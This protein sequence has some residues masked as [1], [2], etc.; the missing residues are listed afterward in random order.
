[1]GRWGWLPDD[2]GVVGNLLQT[3][4]I[5]GLSA[6]IFEEGGR[7]LAFRFWAKDARRWGQGLMMGAGHGGIEAMLLGLV[8]LIN[9]GVLF[10]ISKGAFISLIPIEQM[11][12]VEQQIEAM[13]GLPWSM[14]LLGAVERV[15]AISFHLSASL[16]VMQAVGRGKIKWLL[17][18]VGWHTLLNG[19]AV[20]TAV[21]YTPL[22]AEAALG[23][24]AL[25]SL[26]IIYKLRSTDPAEPEPEPLPDI[27]PLLI[28]RKPISAKHLE[29]SRYD[30]N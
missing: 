22:I 26:L 3:A 1:M 24:I 17:A 4:V 19:V 23:I 14:T 8:G 13:F 11:A 20:F 28:A 30:K 21:S 10:G 9:V 25:F 15:F 6:A 18:A 16:M 27:E 7:Y 12:L 29:K 5:L 2:L